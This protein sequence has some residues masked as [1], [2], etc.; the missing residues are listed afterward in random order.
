MI[1]ELARTRERLRQVR[2]GAVTRVR[3]ELAAAAA[4]DA[5]RASA[6]AVGDRVVD[7]ETGEEGIVIH[8][9]R[10]NIVIPVAQR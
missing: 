4:R 9:T 10:E 6:V 2:A 8:G 3:D 5:A 7:L 1:D